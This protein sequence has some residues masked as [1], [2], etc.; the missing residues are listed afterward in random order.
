ML[1]VEG[2]TDLQDLIKLVSKTLVR[3]TDER[4][5]PKKISIQAQKDV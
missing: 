3:F 2:Q 5:N 4:V 1:E